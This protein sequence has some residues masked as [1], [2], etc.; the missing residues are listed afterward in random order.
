MLVILENKW[1]VNYIQVLPAPIEG[2]ME[3][4]GGCPHQKVFIT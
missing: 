4:I 3:N 1:D 2:A